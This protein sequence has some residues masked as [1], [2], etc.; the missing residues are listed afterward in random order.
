VGN[1]QTKWLSVGN[2]QTNQSFVGNFIPKQPSV[3]NFQTFT[4]ICGYTFYVLSGISGYNRR[5]ECMRMWQTYM[6]M[7]NHHY[8]SFFWHIQCHLRVSST[9]ERTYRDTTPL[10]FVVKNAR[11]A[12]SVLD[13]CS[14]GFILT[15]TVISKKQLHTQV[16]ASMSNTSCLTCVRPY[17]IACTLVVHSSV[18]WRWPA[19]NHSCVA[20][21]KKICIGHFYIQKKTQAASVFD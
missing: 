12:H 17:R 13:A 8:T 15:N 16:C 3:G 10:N 7:K 20:C 21:A 18:S 6:T 1:L 9:C 4:S 14:T 5:N 19:P 11:T 2:T